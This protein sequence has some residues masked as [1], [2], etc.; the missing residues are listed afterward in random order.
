MAN[1][2]SI[3]EMEFEEAFSE[4]ESIVK[5]LEDGQS[6]LKKSV[7]LYERG[8][9]L[10]KHCDKILESAQLRI[11]QISLDKDG[12]VVVEEASLQ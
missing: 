1:K 7:D 6:S 8:V 12:G 2:K 4:L 11:N 9:L 10:K 3:D 5:L